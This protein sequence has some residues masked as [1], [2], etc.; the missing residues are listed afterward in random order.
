M[1]HIWKSGNQEKPGLSL[2][3]R[4]TVNGMV[5]KFKSIPLPSHSSFPKL[6]GAILK[7]C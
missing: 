4:F 5:P 2:P 7:K 1:A 6:Y 3:T